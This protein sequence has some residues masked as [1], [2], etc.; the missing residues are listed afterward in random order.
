MA[1]IER[2]IKLRLT[3][4]AFPRLAR[5]APDRRSVSSV[6]YDTARQDLRRAGIALR[7][8]RDGGR[9]LQTL[10]AQGMQHACVD[11]GAEWVLPVRRRAL[12]PLAFRREEIRRTA[13]V[14]LARLAPR[15]APVFET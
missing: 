14:D 3:R 6:Y 4:R 5:L 15:L 12:E 1:H 2:E 13:G 7:L 9:W 11:Q 8:R 10:K